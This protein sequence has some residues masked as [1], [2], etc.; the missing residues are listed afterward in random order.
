M[1][2]ILETKESQDITTD[3]RLIKISTVGNKFLTNV[4]PHFS[5][6]EYVVCKNIE[7]EILPWRYKVK[8]LL[9]AMNIC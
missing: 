2:N 1:P 5:F 8:N 3:K 4:S 7:W 6:Y 9:M